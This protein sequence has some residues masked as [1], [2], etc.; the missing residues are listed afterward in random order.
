MPRR[1]TRPRR[2]IDWRRDADADRA[3][4]ARLQS[5]AGGRDALARSSSC[6]SGR[7]RAGRHRGRG[8]TGPEQRLGRR[9]LAAAGRRSLGYPG[10]EHDRL[11]VQCGAGSLAVQ[12]TAAR[13]PAHRQRRATLPADRPVGRVSLRVKPALANPA[14][15]VLRWR[16]RDARPRWPSPGRSADDALGASARHRRAARGDPRRDARFAALVPAARGDRGDADCGPAARRRRCTRCW[17]SALHQLEYSRNP[18]RG[19][20]VLG[21]RCGAPAAPVARRRA[22]QCA[23]APLPAR[24]RSAAGAL[25]ARTRPPRVRTRAGCSQ[26][27]AR[28]PGREHW[29][30]ILEA[31]NAHPPMSAAR[32]SVA[33]GA[34]RLPGASLRPADGPPRRVSWLPS[35]L[36]LD[37]PGCGQRAAGFRRRAG[38]RC[39]TPARSSPRAAGGTAGRARARCLRGAGRQDRRAARGR[40]WRHRADRGRHRWRRRVQRVAENLQ[41]LHRQ[42]QLVA[43]DLRRGPALVGRRGDS[44]ASCSMRPARRPASSAAIPTSSCC[45][46]PTTSRA[47]AR[48]QRRILQQCLRLLQARRTAAVFDLLGA[49]GGKRA[50]G[51]G[52]IWRACRGRARV[53]AVSVPD[54]VRLPADLIERPIGM[55]LLPGNAALTDGF[56]YACLTV[57]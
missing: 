47:L 34:R 22:D 18:P 27:L 5:L 19:H 14:A 53:A 15:T 7:R 6:A 13:G 26:A 57:T 43:A 10:L 33:H 21:G 54:G 55:Q 39:R 50:H 45:A 28:E 48:P 25:A 3:P 32:G 31:N 51:R 36:V 42:A 17:W 23:A 9:R 49:A 2:A 41:R 16:P 1:S 56:Y 12:Q 24:A 11:L 8:G 40:G 30:Q 4:G 38:C 46:G 35:A 52:G 29:P 44:I 37:Q 20:G